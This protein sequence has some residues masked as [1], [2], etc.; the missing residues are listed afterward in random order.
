V[1]TNDFGINAEKLQQIRALV[2]A[3]KRVKDGK[4]PTAEQLRLLNQLDSQG[5]IY[6][7]SVGRAAAEFGLDPKTLSGRIKAAGVLAGSDGKYSTRDIDCAIHCDYDN[8][9]TRLTKEQA[10]V[11]AL[12]KAEMLR[13]LVPAKLVER[14]WAGVMADLRQKISFLELPDG[15]K[16][17]IL[18]DLQDIPI[19][20]YFTAASQSDEEDPGRL[21][22]AA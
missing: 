2:D 1:S 13:E 14:V 3:V 22:E 11:V 10:D 15:K 4:P 8:E 21:P 7:W 19:D 6:R 20:D 12:K 5:N 18:A 17:E 16:A 9:K